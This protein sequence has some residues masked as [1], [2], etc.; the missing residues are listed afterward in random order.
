MF[1]FHPIHFLKFLAKSQPQ[2]SY[3]KR[4]SKK[5]KKGVSHSVKVTFRKFKILYFQNET[6]KKIYFSVIFNQ[7]WIKIEKTSQ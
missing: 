2:R 6:C 5:I 4:F 3:K 1:L 7:V